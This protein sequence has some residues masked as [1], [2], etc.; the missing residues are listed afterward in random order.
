MVA[1]TAAD[2]ARARP[3]RQA[4]LGLAVAVLL[5][6][7]LHPAAKIALR[8]LEPAQFT[9]LRAA[10][11]GV[12]LLL[13]CGLTGRLRAVGRELSRP[14]PAIALGTWGSPPATISRWPRSNSWG[15]A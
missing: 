12:A 5:W 13:V 9:F 15:P 10:L 4:Y 14:G 2:A 1:V 3:V 11:A 7:T 6:G 8:G